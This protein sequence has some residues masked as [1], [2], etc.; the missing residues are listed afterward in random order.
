MYPA[1]AAGGPLPSNEDIGSR[2]PNCLRTAMKR[3]MT[4]PMAK[5]SMP[6]IPMTSEEAGTHSG[7]SKPPGRD[8]RKLGL[9]RVSALFNNKRCQQGWAKRQQ[10]PAWLVGDCMKLSPGP[11]SSMR[12]SWMKAPLMS[13]LMLKWK[14]CGG[15]HIWKIFLSGP[16]RKTGSCVTSHLLDQV[17]GDF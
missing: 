8:E 12:T 1:K 7:P 5:S 4:T 16:M 6:W 13:T 2:I 3:M 11:G 9:M 10:E 15:W 14:I 17:K